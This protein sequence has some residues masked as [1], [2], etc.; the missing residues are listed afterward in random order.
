M[1]GFINF[2]DIKDGTE[3][4]EDDTLVFEQGSTD[5][6]G[7]FFL[8]NTNSPDE[9]ELDF[10]AVS[11]L[12]SEEVDAVAG[13]AKESWWGDDET[14]GSGQNDAT[15]LFQLYLQQISEL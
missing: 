10:A 8:K 14:A 11:P 15:Q 12:T 9:E 2:G 4:V 5:A 7:V 1:A 13:G 3:L 6:N